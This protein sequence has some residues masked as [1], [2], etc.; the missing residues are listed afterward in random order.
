VLPHHAE[1]DLLGKDLALNG[2]A[3]LER[4]LGLRVDLD[5]AMAQL[6]IAQ[7]LFRPRQ[8]RAATLHLT[9]DELMRVRGAGAVQLL[10][11]Q[12]QIAHV[13]VG[14]LGGAPG[15][16]V[17]VT[18]EQDAFVRVFEERVRAPLLDVLFVVLS[19]QH[20]AQRELVEDLHTHAPAADDRGVERRQEGSRLAARNR[21]LILLQECRQRPECRIVRRRQNRRLS[22]IARRECVGDACGD[23]SGEKGPDQQRP[24]PPQQNSQQIEHAHRL[25][26]TTVSSTSK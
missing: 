8:I 24:P 1:L 23:A 7:G 12:I 6:E 14:D 19:R 2:G 26:A 11:E 10:D 15:I 20:L 17:L 22:I 25:S 5:R 16:A 18:H 9:G 3:E 21:Q 13:A 4:T